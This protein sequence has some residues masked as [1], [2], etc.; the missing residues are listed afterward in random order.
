MSANVV[1]LDAHTVQDIID[2]IVEVGAV[3]D[4]T[5]Q[6]ADVTADLQARIENVRH[7]V[8]GAGLPRVLALEWL[9]PPFAPGHWVPEMI[10]I[11]G[12]EN[13]AGTAG[14]HSTQTNWGAL[15]DLDPDTLIIMPCGYDLAATKRDADATRA[16]LRDVAPRAIDSSRAYIVDGS[17]YFNRSG[18]RFVIGIEI[19]AGLLHPDVYASPA[20]G[21]AQLWT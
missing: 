21:T 10:E 19:L 1:S 4:A 14:S 8:A 15:K 9:D 12:G 17:A 6:A 20:A 2:S 5:G 13:L 16:R 7:A 3:T 11:A 18:P